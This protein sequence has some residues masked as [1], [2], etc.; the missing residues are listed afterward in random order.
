MV[1]SEI[2]K[3]LQLEGELV[4]YDIVSNGNI[5][6]TYHVFCNKNGIIYCV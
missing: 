4:S 6:T 3:K 5:N 1:I 2:C